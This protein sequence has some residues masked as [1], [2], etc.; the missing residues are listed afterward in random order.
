[1]EINQLRMRRRRRGSRAGTVSPCALL[2][3]D[4][5]NGA[6]QP[7]SSLLDLLKESCAPTL[8]GHAYCT[9]KGKTFEGGP[10]ALVIWT[11]QP[12]LATVPVL[13][14][15]SRSPESTKV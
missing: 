5:R 13:I 12:V 9:E 14:V 11:V 7:G 10:P 4:A 2:A 8:A 1:V 3:K 6:R 15:M